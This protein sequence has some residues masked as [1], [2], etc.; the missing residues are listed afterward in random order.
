MVN[1]NCYDLD[2]VEEERK[3]MEE[4]CDIEE[5]RANKFGKKYYRKKVQHIELE[6][7]MSD[8]KTLVEVAILNG[9][10]PDE[11]I[12]KVHEAI[13]KEIPKT[14]PTNEVDRLQEGII[15]DYMEGNKPDWDMEQDT[16]EEHDQFVQER[17][18]NS[19][20]EEEDEE[21]E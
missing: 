21:D 18:D 15:E 11:I 16:Q 4:E 19:D 12:V 17:V 8:I 10:E 9:K 20:T 5:K 6:K 2:E 13:S 1:K 14:E 3:T 7:S